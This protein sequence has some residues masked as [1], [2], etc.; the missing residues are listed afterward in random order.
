MQTV[1]QQQN[2]RRGSTDRTRTRIT[3][4]RG[5]ELNEQYV[6][7]TQHDEAKTG[8]NENQYPGKRSRGVNGKAKQILRQDLCMYVRSM[9]TMDR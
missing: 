5:R 9:D 8:G 2:E 1:S 3:L 4:D 7:H 6:L